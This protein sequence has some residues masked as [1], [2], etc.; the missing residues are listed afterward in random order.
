MTWLTTRLDIE[1]SC[2]EIITLEPGKDR[3]W[4]FSSPAFPEATNI[5]NPPNIFNEH[6]FEA[7]R[8]NDSKSCPHQI[9]SAYLDSEVDHQLTKQNT[10][11]QPQSGTCNFKMI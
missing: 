7:E 1:M 9:S 3:F 10:P 2:V 8:K 4:Y 11:L 5:A 6:D